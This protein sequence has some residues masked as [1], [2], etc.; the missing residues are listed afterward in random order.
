MTMK[1]WTVVGI[2]VATA[3]GLWSVYTYLNPASSQPTNNLSAS[4]GSSLSIGAGGVGIN[5]GVINNGAIN[6]TG[7]G[8]APSVP[9]AVRDAIQD[10]RNRDGVP[11]EAAAFRQWIAPCLN[12]RLK[13]AGWRYLAE[14][15]QFVRSQPQRSF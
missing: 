6:N 8:T 5:N 14:T 4:G 7:T 1:Q 2:V 12:D 13:G 9:L 10:C 15:D 11:N 3:T